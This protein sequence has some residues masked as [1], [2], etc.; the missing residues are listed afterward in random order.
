MKLNQHH[1]NLINTIRVI[2]TRLPADAKPIFGV[3]VQSQPLL[4]INTVLVYGVRSETP[5]AADV[6]CEQP[7]GPSLA[8]RADNSNKICDRRRAKKYTL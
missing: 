1:A 5:E 8:A 7:R 6:F 4:A 3:K 2:L